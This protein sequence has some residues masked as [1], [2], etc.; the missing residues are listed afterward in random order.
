M[1]QRFQPWAPGRRLQWPTGL[2][3]VTPS[4]AS[5]RTA[6]V[7]VL[8]PLL[9]AV[10]PAAPAPDVAVYVDWVEGRFVAGLG[11]VGVGEA[12]DAADPVNLARFDVDVNPCHRRLYLDLL[13]EPDGAT[14]HAGDAASA[15]LVY[16]FRAELYH[17]NGTLAGSRRITSSAY[18][19]SLGTV[20]AEG[21]YRLD[22]YLLVGAD[23]SWS[24]RVRGLAA[25]GEAL[26]EDRILVSEVEANPEGW[27]AGREW[28]ELHNPGL[29][30]VNVSG[31]TV[32]ATHGTP[33]SRTLQA[34]TVLEPG[35]RLVVTFDDQF[36]DNE[37]E[38]VL[39]VDARGYERD[40]TPELWDEANDD[41]SW[42][43]VGDASDVWAFADAT[44]GEENVD[45]E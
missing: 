27:D 30:P 13:Y 4:L 40:R 14:V 7:L 41:R 19:Y 9:L 33:A 23:V 42:Q 10:P 44:A 28:L 39:L 3:R 11:V 1:S 36:L 17:P 6:L 12:A 31:W 35:D 43:R 29:F 24:L 22:L 16:E 32:H 38:V 20:P 34:G 25:H 5:L 26:C 18:G 37:A 2:G 45:V 15:T 8:L 21:T